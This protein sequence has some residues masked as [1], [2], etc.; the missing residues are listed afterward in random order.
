MDRSFEKNLPYYLLLAFLINFV[1]LAFISD[2]SVGGADDISHY[3]FSRY[4]FI[5]PEF[6]LDPWAKPLFTMLMAPFAQFG[7]MGV[8]ILNILLGLV[9]AWLTYLTAKNPRDI[10]ADEL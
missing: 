8:R 1:I 2:G 10:A 5:H 3:K 9:A 4:A 6:F 7:M